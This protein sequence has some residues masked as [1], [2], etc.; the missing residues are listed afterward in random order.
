MP[1]APSDEEPN[2]KRR[3]YTG[4][5]RTTRWRRRLAG[6]DLSSEDEEA[7]NEDRATVASET[8]PQHN[9]EIDEFGRAADSSIPQYLSLSPTLQNTQNC[10]NPKDEL[11]DSSI[12]DS[13]SPSPHSSIQN[14]EDS[15]DSQVREQNAK[16]CL[17]N[18]FIHD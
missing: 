8:P 4:T 18:R 15:C 12:S 5:S 13:I 3:R 11:A 10:G 7:Q 17:S 6:I 1:S 16:S 2:R 9:I 14:N